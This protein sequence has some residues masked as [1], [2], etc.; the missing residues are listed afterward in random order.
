M[1][2]AGLTT[3][4]EPIEVVRV[5]R[6]YFVADGHKRVAI[7]MQTGR[8][9][10]DAQVSAIAW[11]YAMSSEVEADAIERTAREGEFRRHS[12]LG[13]AVPE[14]RFPL[15]DLVAYGEL[16]QAVES[17]AFGMTER[18]GRVPS[19]AEVA[20]DW[21][22]REFQPVVATGRETVGDL[23]GG[24]TDADVYL[25]MHRL[26][27]AN[28][29]TTCDAPECAADMLLAQQQRDRARSAFGRVV[30]RVR[31]GARSP[32]LLPLAVDAGGGGERGA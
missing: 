1:Q 2:N 10:I 32:S 5:D 12:G 29:G 30:R 20:A 17:Y 25:A 24:C 23:I 15:T 31:G 8:V 9:Y 28:W 3:L 22:Q 26:R 27:R 7:A 13:A 14:V 16:F 21:F 19:R 11:P 6:A 4:D 18:L